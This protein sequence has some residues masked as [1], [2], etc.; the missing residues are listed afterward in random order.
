MEVEVQV[1]VWV[2]V[3]LVERRC[4]W[5]C[6]WSSAGVVCI[7]M[8][9]C[10]YMLSGFLFVSWAMLSGFYCLPPDTLPSLRLLCRSDRQGSEPTNVVMHDLNLKV[11]Y[12]AQIVCINH[13]RTRC[14]SM[15]NIYGWWTRKST[16]VK[17][18]V[19]NSPGT[20]LLL[21]GIA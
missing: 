15:T 12:N 10:I 1:R 18:H 2:W 5:R 19:I 16:F 14:S 7:H 9:I 11:S 3:Q 21:N 20:G 6:N 13:H 8:Y 4:V 17:E